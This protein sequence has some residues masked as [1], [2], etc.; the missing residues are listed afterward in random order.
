MP[1]QK[2]ITLYQFDEL[3]TAKAKEAARDWYRDCIDA[4]DL[5]HT[6]EDFTQ[7]ANLLGVEI[8]TKPYTTRGGA[9]RHE[10]QVSWELHVQ[11]AGASFAGSWRCEPDGVFKIAEY[12]PQ[13][14]ELSRIAG[15][16]AKYPGYS[17]NTGLSHQSSHSRGA[18]ILVFDPED[19]EVFDDDGPAKAIE[20]ALRDLMDWLYKALDAEWEYQTSD[21]VIEENIR[22]NEYHFTEGGKRCN[23]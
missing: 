1:I 11:G 7:I 9:T 4:N 6:I 10:P 2:V 22:A 21:E 3:P 12:A 13:D 17:A 5:E 20:E 16:L 8:K 18:N 23:P 19:N 15:E 14:I